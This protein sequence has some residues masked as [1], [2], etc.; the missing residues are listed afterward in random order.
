V[1]QSL[2]LG[3]IAGQHRRLVAGI[4]SARITHLA[5]EA[6]ALHATNLWDFSA[7]KRLA[8]LVCL[9]HQATISTRHEIVQM[10]IKRMSKLTDRAKQELER[11]RKEERATTEHLIEVFTD[12]LQVSHDA[13]DPVETS[14]Q[15]REV[16]AGH[17]RSRQSFD[18]KR[19][20]QA[21]Y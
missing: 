9:I 12:V 11:L 20:C 17:L 19:A 13:Q 15:I 1:A 8:L 4:R 14:T 16:L 18:P 3:A 6:R 7:P 10:F 2:D 21:I 5:E